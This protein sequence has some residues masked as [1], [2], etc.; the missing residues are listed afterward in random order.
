MAQ[1]EVPTRPRV[2]LGTLRRIVRSLRMWPT[3]F[4]R[5]IHTETEERGIFKSHCPPTRRYDVTTQRPQYIPSENTSNLTYLEG[6]AM[7]YG[8]RRR[9]ITTKSL[10]QNPGQSTCNLWWTN[11]HWDWYLSV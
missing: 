3:A 1:M 4:R 7:N 6:R 10:V 8:V 5:D 11:W 2:E 9:P